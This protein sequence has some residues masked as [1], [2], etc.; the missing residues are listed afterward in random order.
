LRYGAGVVSQT[1]RPSSGLTLRPST[2]AASYD[3]PSSTYHWVAFDQPC[4]NCEQI[5]AWESAAQSD[6][7]NAA[8][9]AEACATDFGG[10][11][12]NCGTLAI[13]DTYGFSKSPD[14]NYTNIMATSTCS[15]TA[16]ST[17]LPPVS[18]KIFVAENGTR[19]VELV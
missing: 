18:F 16:Q 19:R 11:Y 17:K 6:L 1:A 8:A 2:R 7:K 14:L 3:P 5:A 9:A 13:L 10:S 4:A 15:L 12:V